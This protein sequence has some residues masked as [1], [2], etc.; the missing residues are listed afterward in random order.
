VKDED[1]A[2]EIADIS[3]NWEDDSEYVQNLFKL[4]IKEND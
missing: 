2:L 3:Y 1:G 4:T